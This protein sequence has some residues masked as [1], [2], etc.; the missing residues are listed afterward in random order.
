MLSVFV[1]VSDSIYALH[2]SIVSVFA[3]S[4]LDNSY[5]ITSFLNHGRRT[6]YFV[7]LSNNI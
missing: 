7:D 6:T 5:P 2:S 3:T 4:A 1:P